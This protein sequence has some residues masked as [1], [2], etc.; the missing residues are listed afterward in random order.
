MKT[1]AIIMKKIRKHDG[2]FPG[3]PDPTM[4][5]A[6]G[7]DNAEKATSHRKRLSAE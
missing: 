3:A 4:S 7:A 2:T 6:A 1:G 5:G